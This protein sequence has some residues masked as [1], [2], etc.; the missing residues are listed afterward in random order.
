MIISFVFHEYRPAAAGFN[1]H[2]P[3]NACIGKK[4]D[5]YLF[6]T[7]LAIE[8]V[9]VYTVSII[10]YFLLIWGNRIS[11]PLRIKQSILNLHTLQR[12]HSLS[13]KWLSIHSSIH[14]R[15]RQYNQMP[16]YDC[17]YRFNL[18]CL[19]RHDNQT[20][21]WPKLLD[22]IVKRK[23]ILMAIAAVCQSKQDLF[24]YSGEINFL[25]VVK[26]R[27]PLVK[28]LSSIHVRLDDG[29]RSERKLSFI[30][31]SPF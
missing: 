20:K 18:F 25:Y 17:S 4:F 27:Y 23:M 14:P 24:D 19:R 9:N 28:N 10:L 7:D 13:N 31:F 16:L 11:K 22:L 26:R 30:S 5:F 1:I 6:I 21:S 12:R 8:N 29:K 15:Y 2:S 3:I